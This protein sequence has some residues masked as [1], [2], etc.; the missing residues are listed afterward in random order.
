LLYVPPGLTLKISKFWSRLIFTSFLGI[1]K[2]K[3]IIPVHKINRLVFVTQGSVF[4]AWYGP[5]FE[6]NSGYSWFLDV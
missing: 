5:N 2:Q 4:T 1:S 3:A 6:K